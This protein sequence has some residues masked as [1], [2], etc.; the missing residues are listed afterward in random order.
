MEYISPDRVQTVGYLAEPL[1]LRSARV[2][3]VLQ[4]AVDEATGR[5]TSRWVA[6]EMRPT[7]FDPVLVASDACFE[8]STSS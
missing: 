3:P 7:S 8:G 1:I 2:V 4:W 5:P 6:I